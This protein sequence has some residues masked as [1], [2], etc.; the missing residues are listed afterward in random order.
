MQ[1]TQIEGKENGV[2]TPLRGRGAI[3]LP[4]GGCQRNGIRKTRR[5]PFYFMNSTCRITEEESAVVIFN[6]R[7]LATWP[8]PSVPPHFPFWKL[9][10]LPIRSHSLPGNIYSRNMP[11]PSYH[12]ERAD[13][14]YS[15]RQRHTKYSLNL[16]C[17][18][19]IFT[20]IFIMIM[21]RRLRF[22]LTLTSKCMCLP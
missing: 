14:L 3:V 22:C 20:I 5:A 8:D 4:P 11:N 16:P 12:L 2:F 21:K 6:R 17:I 9:G 13:R 7:R 15:V 1:E 10:Y 19:N 18:K